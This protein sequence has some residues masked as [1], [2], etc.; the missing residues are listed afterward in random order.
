MLPLT[1]SAALSSSHFANRPLRILMAAEW[2]AHGYP[3]MKYDAWI[4]VGTWPR[5][6]PSI[7]RPN[8]L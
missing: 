3:E 2:L 4:P 1:E 8:E 7:I 6:V 5:L